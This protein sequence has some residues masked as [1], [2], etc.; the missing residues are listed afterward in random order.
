MTTADREHEEHEERKVAAHEKAAT[1]HDRAVTTEEHKA[2][3]SRK[4]A[5]DH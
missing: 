1:V 3:A 2:A 5:D 4:Q